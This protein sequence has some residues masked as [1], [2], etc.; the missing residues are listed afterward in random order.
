MTFVLFDM[1]E[2]VL[3]LR[4]GRNGRRFFLRSR[5]GP[6]FPSLVSSEYSQLAFGM[7]ACTLN[8]VTGG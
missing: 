1:D 3:T 5:G 4:P 7:Y 8:K 6:A 2:I